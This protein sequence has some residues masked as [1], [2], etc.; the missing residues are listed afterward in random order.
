MLQAGSF[1]IDYN[2]NTIFYEKSY[3]NLS[4][5]RGNRLT[6]RKKQAKNVTL[7]GG[8]NGMSTVRSLIANSCSLSNF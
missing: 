8:S 6:H 7:F 4:S 1:A 2:Y 5:I 3:L